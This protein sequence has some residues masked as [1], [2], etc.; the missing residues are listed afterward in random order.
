[1]GQQPRAIAARLIGFVIGRVA[2]PIEPSGLLEPKTSKAAPNYPDIMPRQQLI[3]SQTITLAGRKALQAVKTYT[4]GY[5][6]VEIGVDV[7]DILTEPLF[8]LHTELIDACRRV[9]GRLDGDP[10]FQEEYR[11]YCVS[12]YTGDPEVF[13]TLHGE[14][15]VG[16]LKDE[17]LPLDEEEVH[18]T[19]QSNIKYGKDD[20]TIVDWD[21]AVLFDP[22]ADFG[23]NIELIQIANY[24]L[25]RARTFDRALDVRL[26][27]IAQLLRT[28]PTRSLFRAREFRGVLREIIQIR[29]ETIIESQAAEHRIK[30]FGDWYAARLYAL[31][32]RKFHIEA[33]QASIQQK[34]DTLE[35]VSTMA[36]ENFSVSF[37]TRL[38][39]ILIG[40]WFV[41]L[42][43]W[44]AYLFLDLYILS[45]R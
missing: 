1:M 36:A 44:F 43:G 20:L 34:L 31:L 7:E 39:F 14:R 37:H 29:T 25:L 26:G 6:I 27:H 9:L 23:A 8:E 28:T 12:N 3:E 11:V 4:P 40:G 5:V 19:L 13:L 24:Q 45:L 22:H 33:W 17:R 32:A 15:F 21:G 41:L 10:Q 30:L 38:D 18:A 2:A 35:D 16:L 42:A